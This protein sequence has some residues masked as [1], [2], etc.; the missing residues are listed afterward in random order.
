[1]FLSPSGSDGQ[2]C[3]SQQAACLS[4]DRA[5]QVAQPGDVVEVAAGHYGNQTL[6][7]DPAKDGQSSQQV[8]FRPAAGAQVTITDLLVLASNVHVI[9]FTVDGS[10]NGQPDI[11]S[12]HDVTIENVK[13]TNFYISGPAARITIKGGDY[14]PYPSCGGGS[15][16]KTLTAGGDDS[17]PAAQPHD[18]L[19][20]G[21]TMHDYTVPSSCPSAHLDCLHVFYHYNLTIRNSTFMRCMHY[22]ILLDSNGVNETENDLVENNFFGDAG[23]AGFAFRGGTDEAF[24]GV[25]VRYNSGGIITPQTTQA[26]LANINWYANVAEDIG[27][28]RNGIDYQYNVVAS[29]G[30]G[31]TDQTAPTGFVDYNNGNLHL[32][33]GSAAI[34]HGKPGNT[35]TTDYDGQNR[36]MGNAPDAGADEAA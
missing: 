14:G 20:D 21:I 35:P 1:V 13:A 30:C 12:G 32:K 33:A 31:S 7:D 6:S 9:G 26:Q 2:S 3:R 8:V 22:G 29:G 5:Y 25:T 4:F 23:V 17:N 16:I 34:N 19:I 18:I 36:P 24:D 11:R 27:S 28:C 15:Q 10:S